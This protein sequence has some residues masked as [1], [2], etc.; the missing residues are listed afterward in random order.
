M[1]S[2][3]STHTSVTTT[4][5]PLSANAASALNLLHNHPAFQALQPLLV[6]NTI[7]PVPSGSTSWL[8]TEAQAHAAA[9]NAGV[10]YRSVAV[11]VPIGLFSSTVVTTTAFVDAEDGLVVVFQAPLGLCGVNRFSIVREGEGGE[12]GGE[13]ALVL[14]EEARLSGCRLMM[15][16]VVRTELESHGEAGRAF[17]RKLVEMDGEGGK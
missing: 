1:P 7:I 12:N 10:E 15:P 6:K 16:F 11:A 5:L 3:N 2:F 13:G 8:V 17:G 14:R 4:P 9:H